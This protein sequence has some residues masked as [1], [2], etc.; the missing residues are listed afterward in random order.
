MAEPPA[1][2][3]RDSVVWEV[4]SVIP[5]A[6]PVPTKTGVL[7]RVARTVGAE[8]PLRLRDRRPLAP[9]AVPRHPGQ[10]T[11]EWLTGALCR[12]VPGAR[13]VSAK[14]ASAPTSGTTT[15][16]ALELTYDATGVS[17]GL[18]R[19]V[20]VKCTS[21]M[22]Q[23]L[24][25]GMGGLISGEAGFY[26]RVRPG[27]DIEAPRGYFGSVDPRSWRS[28]VVI[29]DVVRTRRARFWQPETPVSRSQIEDL[30][31]NM[32]SWHGALWES[33][34]LQ[35]WNW[36][37]TPAEQG[38]LIDSLLGLADSTRAG[39]R[40]AERV[41]PG[42]LHGRQA[43]LLK[44]MRRSMSLLGRRPHTYLHGDLHIA[45][46]YL[47]SEG[48]MGVCDWQVGLKGGWAY[49]FAY[50][51]STGLAAADRRNWEVGLLRFYLERL[52]AAGGRPA[53]FEDAWL[54]YRQA[55][56][57]PFFAWIYTLG[58]SR[59]QP[60]FQPDSVSLTMIARIAAAIDELD[61]LAAIGL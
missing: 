39:A 38:R 35:E 52:E 5:P 47:T 6:E 36:L 58:R 18:P 11:L 2:M 26:E 60:R 4:E 20:F 32:A 1:S 21:S 27:L 14:P 3:E 40:R 17:A 28:V 51:L 25:L 31:A 54:T 16:Q 48:S 7:R 15:R 29:E 12:Q 49:D 10:L 9:G 44:G 34:S 59:L 46:A 61:S 45:N 23:R 56:F 19:H 42:P 24:M 37:R 8:V 41:I 57:Y 43:D 55:T 50:L 33:P 13:V 30:V 22:A 53:S